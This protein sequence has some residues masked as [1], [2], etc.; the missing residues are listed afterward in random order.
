MSI[1][2]L[3]N[4]ISSY[5]QRYFTTVESCFLWGSISQLMGVTS[6]WLHAQLHPPGTW[7]FFHHKTSST[8][9]ASWASVPVIG[10]LNRAKQLVRTTPYNEVFLGGTAQSSILLHYAFSLKY[11]AT[12]VLLNR[13]PPYTVFLIFGSFLNIQKRTLGPKNW[14]TTSLFISTRNALPSLGP[15]PDFSWVKW[16]IPKNAGWFLWTGKH[17]KPPWKLGFGVTPR[18]V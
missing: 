13:K 14:D 12:G 6:P 11:P 5:K 9:W 16:G 8:S 2:S 1:V 17:G 15:F 10:G 4:G 7:N 18:S 3:W